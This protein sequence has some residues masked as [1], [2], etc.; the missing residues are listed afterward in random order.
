MTLF[1]PDEGIFVKS[2]N[3]KRLFQAADLLFLKP[4]SSTPHTHEG[5]HFYPLLV[6]YFEGNNSPE[7]SSGVGGNPV[8]SKCRRRIN[9]RAP[10]STEGCRPESSIFFNTNRSMSLRG[11]L[12]FEIGGADGRWGFTNAQ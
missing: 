7:I 11:H 12:V 5:F 9:V 2:T 4:T 6:N 1:L 3:L 10:V 8:R